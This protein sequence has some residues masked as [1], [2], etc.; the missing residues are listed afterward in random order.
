MDHSVGS[1]YRSGSRIPASAPRI[2]SSDRV[3]SKLRETCHACALSK[4]RCSKE[5]P[6]CARCS[7]RGVTCEY[8]VTKRPGRKRDPNKSTLIR[9]SH[10]E[11]GFDASAVAGPQGTNANCMWI[12]DVL[13]TVVASGHGGGGTS[14]DEYL[15][16]TRADANS[17]MLWPLTTNEG[18]DMAGDMSDFLMPLMTPLSTTTFTVKTPDFLNASVHVSA[19]NTPDN[20][21]PMQDSSSVLQLLVPDGAREGRDAAVEEALSLDF[22][23]TSSSRSLS[24][25]PVS[26]PSSSRV[27]DDSDSS[28][29]PSSCCCL[30][31]ALE[32]MA[33]L[34]S[35]DLIHPPGKSV[36][37]SRK[38]A[39][40]D[41]PLFGYPPTSPLL[42]ATFT[43]NKQ[44]IEALSTMLHGSCQENVYLLTCMSMIVFKVLRRYEVVAGQSVSTDMHVVS[45]SLYEN[46]ARQ[47]HGD[48]DGHSHRRVAAQLVL[49]ELHL[50]Q[51]LVNR[52]SSRL[53]HNLDRTADDGVD[54]E[55]SDGTLEYR[56]TLVEDKAETS[57]FSAA[58]LSQIDCDL[59]KGLVM[60]SSS[61]ISMLR[62]I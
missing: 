57:F 4:V 20:N 9:G 2:S 6:S 31:K 10:C 35:S 47:R 55:N 41:E 40:Q 58:T 62:R 3:P 50:V 30:V 52:L 15:D 26:P 8:I 46:D 37:T 11:G 32:I 27:A 18:L 38:N 56:D 39:V 28:A 21:Q 44:T 53:R 24:S 17:P 54:S 45:D 36:L 14:N 1:N 7:K 19:P 25:V 51:Q 61:I 33:K 16:S 34:S 29:T 12:E 22:F 48:R 43:A 42:N 60:L 59:R 13:P 49:G 23:S 5:K